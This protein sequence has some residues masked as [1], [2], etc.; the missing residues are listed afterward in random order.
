MEPTN[1]INSTAATS[2]QLPSW[3]YYQVCNT[4]EA[5]AAAGTAVYAN[6]TWN[7]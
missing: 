1:N 2:P 7:S 5:G 3:N 6:R 4:I